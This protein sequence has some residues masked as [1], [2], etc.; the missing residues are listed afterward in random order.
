MFLPD[1]PPAIKMSNM[2]H[3][4]GARASF[5]VRRGVNL[6][7]VAAR[8]TCSKCSEDSRLHQLMKKDREDP[9]DAVLDCCMILLYAF[10]CF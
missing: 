7:V 9:R 8:A 1:A 10:F 4:D 2:R 5:M 3:N 6:D